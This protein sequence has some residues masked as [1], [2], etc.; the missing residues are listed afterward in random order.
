MG[1]ITEGIHSLAITAWVG[2]LWV[3]GLMAAPTLFHYLPDRTLAGSIAARLFTYVALIGLACAGYL[4]LFRLVRFGGHSFRQA[5][6][7]V[8]LA[9]LLFTLAGQ[10]GV[11]PILASLKQ[12]ALPHEVMESVFRDRFATWHGV[13]SV[14]YLIEC[15]LGAILVW[16]QPNAPR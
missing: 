7:W 16:L 14:I 10:F 9:M 13:A 1:R 3:I 12:E 6:F 4:L 5:F 2:S 8:V 11:Q 15:A